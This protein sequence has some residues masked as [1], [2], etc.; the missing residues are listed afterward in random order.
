MKKDEVFWSWIQ[1]GV[2]FYFGDKKFKGFSWVIML[3]VLPKIKNT[4]INSVNFGVEVRKVVTQSAKFV[5]KSKT[6]FNLGWWLLASLIK[7]TY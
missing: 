7:E 1:S 6:V 3:W 4:N 2:C 5:Y